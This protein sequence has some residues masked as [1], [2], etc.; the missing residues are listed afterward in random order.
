MRHI[1]QEKQLSLVAGKPKKKVVSM[2]SSEFHSESLQRE[3]KRFS[4]IWRFERLMRQPY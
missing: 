1:L 3:N 4:K 2:I